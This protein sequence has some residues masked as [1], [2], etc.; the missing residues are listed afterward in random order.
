MRDVC[1]KIKLSRN[2]LSGILLR[3]LL[4]EISQMPVFMKVRL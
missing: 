3:L 1:L 2:L 4:S